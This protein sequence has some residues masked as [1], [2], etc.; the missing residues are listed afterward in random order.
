MV[1]KARETTY[2]AGKP[3]FY[4]PAA[5][6]TAG[7]KTDETIRTS[8]GN[9]GNLHGKALFAKYL[10][11]HGGYAGQRE[12]GYMAWL[13]SHIAAN[14]LAGDVKGAQEVTALALCAV[15]EACQDGHKWDVAFL[16][17]LL[18][19]PPPRVFSCRGSSANPRMR[20]FS[21]LVPQSWASTTLTFVREMD[22]MASR[23]A[24]A[25]GSA[26]SSRSQKAEDVAT[27]KKRLR[28]PKKPKDGQEK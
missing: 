13:L 1:I 3:L 4:V 5:G 25:T 21:P 17:A 7:I 14:L 12:L 28:Y 8:S 26:S 19:E 11:K 27:P 20:A 23:R 18:E 2:V 10:T 15:D 24:E 9:I 22:L 6:G 16:I